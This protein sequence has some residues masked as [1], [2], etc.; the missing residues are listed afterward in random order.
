MTEI[1]LICIFSGLS[2]KM[3]LH[4]F[5]FSI[6][7]PIEYSVHFFRVIISDEKYS[8]IYV[9]VVVPVPPRPCD[10]PRDSAA[11]LQP[12][13]AAAFLRRAVDLL[14]ADLAAG[15]GALRLLDALPTAPRLKV[16]KVEVVF[17]DIG[18]S[19]QTTVLPIRIANK[20][21]FLQ[22]IDIQRFTDLI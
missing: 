18:P 10:P 13:D 12:H 5:S 19:S 17:S 8:F 11:S 7:F 20:K 21:F 2:Q 15:L 6:L 1:G 4:L 3:F 14:A 22:F 16:G 9:E